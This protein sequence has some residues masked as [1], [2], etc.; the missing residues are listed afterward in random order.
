MTIHRAKGLEFDVVILPDLQRSV[1]SSERPLLYW[2][3]IATGPGE[4]GI[5]LASRADSA[6]EDGGAD[7]LERWM[8][9]LGAEREALEL[10]RLAY[11]A[12]TRARHRL[13]LIGS[14]SVSQKKEAIAL[15]RPRRASLLGFLWPVL[16]P[17]FE[18]ALAAQP[19]ELATRSSERRRLTAPPARRLPSDLRLPDPPPLP[20][21]PVLRIRGEPEASIRPAFDW[22]GAI[23]QSVGQVVHAEL[24][25]M[26]D[27]GAEPEDTARR[28]ARWRRELAALGIDE[29]HQEAAVMRARRAMTTVA[30]SALAA[31]L[32]DPAA[33]DG[34]SELALTALI[35]GVAQSLRIDRTFVDE[36]GTR[37]VVDWKTSA[38]EGGDPE[39]F[40]DRELERYRGQLERYARTMSLLEPKR[41]LKVGLYFPLLDAWRGL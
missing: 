13:H 1:R 33:R 30:G 22:A 12:A 14:A 6:E 9:K 39:A 28:E 8:R 20:R 23:A 17:H 41:P 38:H 31:R 19:V 10:G 35:D 11:V 4:R 34:S 15:N 5:V 32:L 3:A 40:L 18:E 27:P 21:A 26:T 24:Q 2:T 25:R 29:A 16:A 7:P 36:T 37:W